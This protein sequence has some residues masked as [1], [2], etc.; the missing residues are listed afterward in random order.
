MYTYTFSDPR[1][2][3]Y[4]ILIKELVTWI[5]LR[6]ILEEITSFVNNYMKLT[7]QFLEYLKII[8]LFYKNTIKEKLMWKINSCS[9]I[10]LKETF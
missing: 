6:K 5:L 1:L 8:N 4:L 7:I 3:N 10:G 9:S 2:S